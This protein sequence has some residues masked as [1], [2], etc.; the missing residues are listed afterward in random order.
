[1]PVI[2]KIASQKKSGV[3]VSVFVDD[4]FLAG[5]SRK[6]LRTLG[7]AVG[8]EVGQELRQRII[9]QSAYESALASLTRRDHSGAEIR[10]KLAQKR[11]DR[12]IVDAVLQELKRNQFVDDQR[13]ARGWVERRTAFRP[14]GRRLL[15][16][17]LEQRGVPEEIIRNV[18]DEFS[19]DEE[20][21]A[22]VGLI[23]KKLRE[24]RACEPEVKKRR[25]L[26]FLARRG[27]SYSDI[28]QVLTDHFPDVF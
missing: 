1:M 25:L 11:F 18:L 3:R 8:Q 26:G 4:T 21:E 24:L 28:R 5:V 13:F 16:V 22:L 23:H 6:A 9:Y 14:R 20:S 27:F 17:E 12:E 19:P 7:I 15:A 10:R 2:T